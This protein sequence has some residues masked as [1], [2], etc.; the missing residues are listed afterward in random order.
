MEIGDWVMLEEWAF[1]S[2][3]DEMCRD[4][5]WGGFHG[6]TEFSWGKAVVFN[7][8][9]SVLLFSWGR[10]WSS[11][12]ERRARRDFW[13]GL[14]D[15]PLALEVSVNP[16]PHSPPNSHKLCA[17]AVSYGPSGSLRSGNPMPT[18]RRGRAGAR[19][20]HSFSLTLKT[21]DW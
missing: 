21:E 15:V 18:A 4:Y 12:R 17:F 9:F 2:R 5:I 3:R 8:H 1:L 20:S 19:P 6:D 16:H 14:L 10:Y 13:D 11:R 7:F